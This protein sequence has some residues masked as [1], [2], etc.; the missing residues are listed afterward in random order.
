MNMFEIY[1]TRKSPSFRQYILKKVPK[2]LQVLPVRAR[3]ATARARLV[4]FEFPTFRFSYFPN[5]RF[6]DFLN[7]L[8]D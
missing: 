1:Y 8:N 4:I 6:S 3:L 5:F 7:F 2:Y